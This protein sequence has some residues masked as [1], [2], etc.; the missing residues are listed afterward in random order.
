M[1]IRFLVKMIPFE[2]EFVELPAEKIPE[3]TLE[4]I[5]W[6]IYTL[7]VILLSIRFLVNLIRLYKRISEHPKHKKQSLIYVLLSEYRIPHSFFK[8]IFVNQKRF[9]EDQIPNA[10]ISAKSKT[11][12]QLV[13]KLIKHCEQIAG[14]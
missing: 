4:T 9:E 10:V 5:L 8:Y 6:L 3:L 14:A 12:L 11:K 7:G 1:L 13:Q 2:T